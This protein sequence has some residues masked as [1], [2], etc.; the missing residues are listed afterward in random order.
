M[1]YKAR[2]GIL[3]KKICDEWLLIAVGEASKHC[4]YVR[5]INDTLAWYWQ[6]IAK[7]IDTEKIIDEAESAFDAS[8]NQ[9][10]EDLNTLIDQLCSMGYLV[11][12][13]RI[14]EGME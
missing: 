10:E 14:P 11:E 9:I 6:R 7:G 3:L 4:L 8:R 1:N 13:L 5:Q 12:T 2:E